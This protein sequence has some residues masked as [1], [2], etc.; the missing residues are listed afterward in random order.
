MILLQSLSE[1]S[2]T[3]PISSDTQ[4]VYLLSDTSMCKNIT[5]TIAGKLKS[6]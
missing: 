4:V 3:L 6:T 2:K 1:T 5:D